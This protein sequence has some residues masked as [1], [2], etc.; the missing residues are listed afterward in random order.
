MELQ[1]DIKS[2]NQVVPY[3]SLFIFKRTTYSLLAFKST[4]RK[5]D[6]NR[7]TALFRFSPGRTLLS[8]CNLSVEESVIPS[9]HGL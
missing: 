2:E 8:L 9:F 4:S 3:F 5:P 1:H 7:F 6:L